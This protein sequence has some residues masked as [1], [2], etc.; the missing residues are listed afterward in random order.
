MVFVTVSYTVF[1][2]CVVYGVGYGVGDCDDCG[3]VNIGGGVGLGEVG[4]IGGFSA[5]KYQAW[6]VGAAVSPSGEGIAAN[7]S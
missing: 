6:V 7:R 4:H 2:D 5:D 3:V 1:C